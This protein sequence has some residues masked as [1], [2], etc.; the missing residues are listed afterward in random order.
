MNTLYPLLVRRFP[1]EA[2]EMPFPIEEQTP[3]VTKI[4]LVMGLG[5]VGF[6]SP[7]QL[8]ENS[9]DILKDSLDHCNSGS[10]LKGV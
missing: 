5:I 7:R 3:P 8:H 9:S 2:A 6:F 1:I 10:G 4:Y